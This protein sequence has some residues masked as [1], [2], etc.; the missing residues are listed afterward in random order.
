MLDQEIEEMIADLLE[1]LPAWKSDT[2]NLVK[3]MRN[4]YEQ[5]GEL[6][7]R[8]IETLEKMVQELEGK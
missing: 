1:R 5:R 8:Q 2:I 6:S 3:S 7:E 4:Q